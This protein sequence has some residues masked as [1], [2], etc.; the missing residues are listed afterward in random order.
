MGKGEIRQILLTYY[1]KCGI[2][3]AS[4]EKVVE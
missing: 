3:L 1:K 2:A 4:D